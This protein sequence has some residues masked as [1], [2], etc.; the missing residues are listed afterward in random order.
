[1]KVTSGRTRI[2]GSLVCWASAVSP[3]ASHY[4]ATGLVGGVPT[5]EV[6]ETLSGALDGMRSAIVRAEAIKAAEVLRAKRLHPAFAPI[7]ID[8]LDWRSRVFR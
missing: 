4:S 7:A 3:L 2:R 1:M 6:S 5:T 8:V